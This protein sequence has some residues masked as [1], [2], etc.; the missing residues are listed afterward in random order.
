MARRESK[1]AS[2]FQRRTS[3]LIY[4]GKAIVMIRNAGN[5]QPNMT[6]WQVVDVRLDPVHQPSV[7][8]FETREAS[9]QVAVRNARSPG[10]EVGL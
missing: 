10:R 8:T 3:N 7:G 5:G 1:A 6:A 4:V 2:K 9:P